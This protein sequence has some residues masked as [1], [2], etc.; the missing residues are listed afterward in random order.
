VDFDNRCF[1]DR[2]SKIQDA[3]WF[4]SNLS[5]D[6]RWNMECFTGLKE[7]SF[8]IEQC[9]DWR[10]THVRNIER[11]CPKLIEL[12]PILFGH[13]QFVYTN[14]QSQVSKWFRSIISIHP[15]RKSRREDLKQI[16]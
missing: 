3:F 13:V 1:N 12:T 9:A 8:I 5:D 16:L 6:C 11:Y 15:G 2:H 7:S 10:I 14:N 4:G